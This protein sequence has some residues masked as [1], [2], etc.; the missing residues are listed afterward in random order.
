MTTWLKIGTFLAV[1]LGFG[2]LVLVH[3]AETKRG[4]QEIAS[5][6]SQLEA[7]N[8]LQGENQRLSEQLRAA[9]EALLTERGELLRSRAQNQ[10]LRQLEQENAQLKTKW[11]RLTNE[12]PAV[13][14]PDAGATA[15]PPPIPDAGNV[16]QLGAIELTHGVPNR[17]D[18]GNGQQL[19]I[20]PLLLDN[21]SLQMDLALVARN[22]AGQEN[23]LASPRVT[24]QEGQ[25]VS[26]SVGSRMIS[27]EATL[28]LDLEEEP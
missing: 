27:F 5:L 19:L 9:R 24:A 3:Q 22:A 18:L 8:Q 23:V 10:A 12:P 14:T 6:R 25:R 4:Q 21:G 15:S 2:A 17:F 1:I 28:K 11:E 13:A 20:T 26:I 16:I 7:A